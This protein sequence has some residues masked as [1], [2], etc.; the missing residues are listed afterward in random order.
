MNTVDLK[1]SFASLI[2]PGIG[3]NG[4]SGANIKTLL[5]NIAD[6]LLNKETDANLLAGL[7]TYDSAKN[8]TTGAG[9]F[10]A[11]ILMQANKA[12][13][14]A[15]KPADWDAAVISPSE[16]DIENGIAVLDGSKQLAWN[17]SAYERLYRDHSQTGNTGGAPEVVGSYTLPANKLDVE[18]Q[19]L[20]IKA[21]GKCANN[22]N[23]KVLTLNV[24]G[25]VIIT[26][27][28][29]QDD[30]S[31]SIEAVLTMTD[32]SEMLA[33]SELRATG[34]GAFDNAINTESGVSVDFT[35]DMDIEIEVTG[36]SADDMVLCGLEIFK[37][38][39]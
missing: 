20:R 1:A 26:S 38:K 39:D 19:Q 14:G 32:T 30:G 16:K 27:S 13:T 22:G 24:D 17:R 29:S 25:V 21:Y 23:S 33:F 7:T 12:T 5:N 6:S 2:D 4:I 3:N 9:C 36:V 11:G 31:W 15:Y 37:I 18:F 35:S 8:Y 34:S 10:Y 28:S